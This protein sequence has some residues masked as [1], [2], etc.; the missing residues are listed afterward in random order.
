MT[1]NQ[2]E[3]YI[4]FAIDIVSSKKLSF[5]KDYGTE[6][7]LNT[8][9]EQINNKY[10]TA[11]LGSE[12]T[13]DQDVHGKLFSIKEGDMLMGILPINSATITQH[14][15]YDLNK[16]FYSAGF[17]QDIR[18]WLKNYESLQFY[19]GI[20]YN[21]TLQKKINRESS[22]D[23]MNGSVISAPKYLL[24]SYNHDAP[25]NK[26]IGNAANSLDNLPF[27]LRTSVL[28]DNFENDELI[29]SEPLSA[30]MQLLFKSTYTSIDDVENIYSIRKILFFNT[31]NSD[32][33]KSDNYPSYYLL[34]ALLDSV[35][36]VKAY[37]NITEKMQV[38][39]NQTMDQRSDVET[40]FTKFPYFISELSVDDVA[41]QTRKKYSSRISNIINKI[42]LESI[43][44]N[45][46]L[47]HHQLKEL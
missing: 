3:R 47:L 46:K 4:G 22:L 29:E 14:I 2:D 41:K 23:V 27:R 38:D 35:Y 30:L 16:I 34:A 31:F 1:N 24:S 9:A 18:K 11:I 15:Y 44:V 43:R 12:S 33:L 28:E 6:D 20:V 10:R 37:Q 26:T 5:N 32:T 21:G 40:D 19:V 39:F 17:Q 13:Y 7:I 42:D 8:L 36:N 45:Q 25:K